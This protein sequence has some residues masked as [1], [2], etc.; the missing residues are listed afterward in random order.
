MWLIAL[1]FA[2]AAFLLVTNYTAN[3]WVALVVAVVTFIV[4]FL[5]LTY[6]LFTL[7]CILVGIF[8]LLMVTTLIKINTK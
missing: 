2:W 7:L 4:F 6:E 5:I 8:L 3:L 1:A